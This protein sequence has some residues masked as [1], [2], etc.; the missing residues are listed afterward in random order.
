MRSDRGAKIDHNKDGNN[1]RKDEAAMFDSSITNDTN[2]TIISKIPSSCQLDGI[3]SKI[4][5]SW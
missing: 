5:S 4:P 2:P 1:G 3:F